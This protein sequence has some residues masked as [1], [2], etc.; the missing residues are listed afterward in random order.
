MKLFYRS[1]SDSIL[2]LFESFKAVMTEIKEMPSPHVMI[3]SKRVFLSS[4]TYHIEGEL[5]PCDTLW[6]MFDRFYLEK[7]ERDR[8]KQTISRYLNDLFVRNMKKIQKN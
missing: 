1:E 2:H 7:D 6:E 8:I 3:S 4:S 5:I